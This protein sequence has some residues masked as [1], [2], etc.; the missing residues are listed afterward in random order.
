[1]WLERVRNQGLTGPRATSAYDVVDRL[2]AVQSQDLNGARLAVRARSTG[3]QAADVDAAIDDG[4]LVVGWLNRGTLHLVARD[5]YWWLHSVTTPQL[6]TGTA[7]RL[8]Q[9]GVD[10]DA[11]ERGVRAMLRALDR[12]GPL[13]RAELRERVRSA[14]VAVD[15]QAMVH[16]LALASRRG[17]MVRGPLR[18]REQTWVRTAEWLPPRNAPVDRDETL[19]RLAG[20]YLRS[21][22]PASD[23]DLARWAGVP[24]RDARAAL[25]AV[26]GDLVERADGLVA[27]K[28]RVRKTPCPPPRLLGAF[29]PL[30]LGW[31]S[32][33]DVLVSAAAQRLVTDNG[34]FRPFLL[35]DAVAVGTWRLR[36]GRVVL[37][38]FEPLDVTVDA[39]LAEDG[40]DV[41]RFLGGA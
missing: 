39:A 37:D 18:G 13:L 34:L 5:D 16:L 33:A 25:G 32:R 41:T 36:A 21:H 11:A 26:R 23:R 17:D 15:G 27:L 28:G 8:R 9:E 29:E 38:P 19:A 24:L 7:T 20:R 1:L 22:S 40:T 6:A 31:T 14:G 12:D 30:L 10:A 2:L 4:S 35:V 3:L